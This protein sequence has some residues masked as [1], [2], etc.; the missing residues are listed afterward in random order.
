MTCTSLDTLFENSP[1]FG[2]KTKRFKSLFKPGTQDYLKG[3]RTSVIEQ[4]VRFNGCQLTGNVKPRSVVD[5]G[6]V[7]FEFEALWLA[8]S[9]HVIAER[10]L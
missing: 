9:C 4:S 1:K 5:K 8:T 2:L 10:A 7:E 6:N 3:Q